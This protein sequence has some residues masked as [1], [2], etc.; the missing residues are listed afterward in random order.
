MQDA[1]LLSLQVG[2]AEFGSTM[3]TEAGT[4]KL[5]LFLVYFGGL[6]VLPGWWKQADPLRKTRVNLFSLAG[7]VLWGG[8]LSLFWPFPQPWGFMLAATISLSTQLASPWLTAKDR[9]VA[10]R[11]FRRA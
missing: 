11:E 7:C 6:F 2:K 8:I 5:P 3:F 10:K 9:E 1:L 4:P